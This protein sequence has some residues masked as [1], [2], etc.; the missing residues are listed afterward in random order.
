M[1]KYLKAILIALSILA[2][3]MPPPPPEGK[4]RV[5]VTEKTAVVRE[6][7]QN[8]AAIVANVSKG[9]ELAFDKK[10]KGWY[11]VTLLTNVSGWIHES[12]V[13]PIYYKTVIAV[14]K[15]DL[16]ASPTDQS[17]TVRSVEKGTQLTI[18]NVKD[19]WSQVRVGET[20][21]VGWVKTS[22]LSQQVSPARYLVLYS[23]ERSNIR[24]GPGTGYSTMT[25]I[26][27]NT[28]LEGLETSGNWYQ[29]R[30][31]N[32][33]TGW[34]FKEL[35]TQKP[36]PTLVITTN[37][38]VRAGP[39]M[40]Y[41]VITTLRKNSR[42]KKLNTKQEWYLI[43]STDGRLGWIHKSLVDKNGEGVPG[44]ILDIIR[45]YFAIDNGNIRSGPST[46]QSIVT[47]VTPGTNL[48]ILS[49][50]GQW[51]RVELPD[52]R[53]GWIDQSLVTSIKGR[54]IITLDRA[55]IR[56]A[57]GTDSRLITQVD[58]GTE[59]VTL[60]ARSDWYEVQL[61]RGGTGWISKKLVSRSKY[62]VLFVSKVAELR[63][64]PGQSYRVRTR[65][66]PGNE[67]VYFAKQGN[68]YHVQLPSGDQPGWI[69]NDYVTVPKYGYGLTLEKAVTRRGPGTTYETLATL[70]AGTELPILDAQ[71]NWFRIELPD[72]SIGWIRQDLV[73]KGNYKPLISIKEGNIRE[74]PGLDYPIMSKIELGVELTQLARRGEWHGV[75]LPNGEF[76][77]INNSLVATT[78][79]GSVRTIESANLR[80]GPGLDYKVKN[81][82]SRGTR[83]TLI[84]YFGDW[85]QVELPGEEVGWIL[86]KLVSRI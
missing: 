52:G 5:R 18:I 62:R 14:K 23:T 61:P 78:T 21:E 71:Q 27:S 69:H 34:I 2:N 24:S 9:A 83:L 38:N 22:D 20:K 13:E 28:L 86:K 31:P 26:E 72:G 58:P 37:S 43:E 1:V 40:E 41:G 29:V 59:M 75:K 68:W 30:L 32:N 45:D 36:Y 12:S 46:S 16:K 77:W 64:G 79:Y 49:S 44:Q 25:T 66:E 47:K 8:N 73:K 4:G 51:Y 63:E 33:T 17:A 57:P 80:Y 84:D 11:H 60:G 56:E 81:S 55:N 74:G 39:G 3:C 48:N 19:D 82:V 65:L 53:T 67:L 15:I 35:V 54:I 70:D 85:Y 10:E 7:P 6:H 42:V 50:Q 76:G